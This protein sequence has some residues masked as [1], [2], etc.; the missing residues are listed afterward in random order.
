M[1]DAEKS[2]IENVSVEMANGKHTKLRETWC[3][4]VFP[5]RQMMFMKSWGFFSKLNLSIQVFAALALCHE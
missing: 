1:L 5:L 2:D 4:C 3:Y